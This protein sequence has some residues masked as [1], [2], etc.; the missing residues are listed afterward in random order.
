M[1]CT[2]FLTIR[3]SSIADAHHR[4][5]LCSGMLFANPVPTEHSIAQEH[6]ED[7]IKQAIETAE[8]AGVVGSENTPFI[9]N[10]IQN[11]SQG[12]SV[13]ANRALVESNVRR[14][15]RTAVEL[16]SLEQEESNTLPSYVD[17]TL[18]LLRFIFDC[19][20]LILA[21]SCKSRA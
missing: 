11:L 17:Q 1:L 14:G 8:E 5:P 7:I 9:L 10:A 13:E 18:F 2:S 21:V 6:M 12:K 3:D 19:L 4:L 15:A 16:C 20:K